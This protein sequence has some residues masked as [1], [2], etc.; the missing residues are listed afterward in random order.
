MWAAAL[1]PASYLMCV[2]KQAGVDAAAYPKLDLLLGHDV[3]GL[4]WV[5]DMRDYFPVGAGGVYGV[6]SAGP[7]GFGNGGK[8]AATVQLQAAQMP[9]HKHVVN[10]AAHAH[11][12]NDPGHAHP[13]SNNFPANPG[14]AG[15]TRLHVLASAADEL[16][17]GQKY[18]VPYNNNY[19]GGNGSDTAGAGTG[20]G[21][22][23]NTTG[24]S[25]NDAG[26]D[27]THENRPPFRALNFVIK[28]L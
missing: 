16:A 23:G 14:G 7:A 4:I 19:A 3:D 20:I 22:Y 1:A 28:A 6:G 8:D 15:W 10:E 2:G 9:R 25:M 18:Q 26:A 21:I 12:V 17:P 13:L 24:V 11:G 27:G 5:P